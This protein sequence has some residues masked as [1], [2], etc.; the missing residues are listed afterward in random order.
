MLIH[1][2]GRYKTRSGRNATNT[3][4]LF[5]DHDRELINRRYDELAETAI[6]LHQLSDLELNQH[7]FDG[8]KFL[9]ELMHYH[10]GG[11]MLDPSHD[12]LAKLINR[13]VIKVTGETVWEYFN[14][15]TEPD[16]ATPQDA[17]R[18]MAR[19]RDRLARFKTAQ[20]TSI[21]EF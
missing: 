11:K 9:K 13:A 2:S 6:T 19:Q 17:A 12:Q 7:D 15:N 3:F 16:M 14:L 4:Y 21:W 10:H 18:Q 20:Q 1:H 8:L 5:D